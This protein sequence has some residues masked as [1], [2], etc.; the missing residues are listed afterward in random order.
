MAYIG[1]QSATAFT[2]FDKQII[3]GNGGT[4]YT[5]SH[6]V[7]NEQEIEV[8]VNN[9]RQEG[10]SG[11]AFTVSG[12]QITFT[13]AVASSDSCY[14][15]FQ[16]KAIQTVV[17]PDGSVTAAKLAAGVQGV[18]GITTA[19]TSGTAM[20]IDSSNRITTPARPSFSAYRTAG[21]GSG[22]TGV[23]VF[24]NEDHDIGSCFNTSD[25]K[26]TAPIAGIYHFDVLGFYCLNAAGSA[27]TPASY[28]SYIYK[29][30][31]DMAGVVAIHYDYF[32]TGATY[33]A[34]NMSITLQLAASDTIYFG[35]NS[36]TYLYADSQRGYATFSGYLVG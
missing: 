4:T 15:N 22:T 23:I 9:V 29:N 31:T 26:F 3:T 12:N 7:A 16:G 19:S 6:A 21:S 17:P 32:N 27:C 36:S 35:T 10:G 34:V 33:P 24:N 14:V 13:G 8:F 25:G 5:L 28:F 18:A 20:S 2:S 30:T 11:K 1:N